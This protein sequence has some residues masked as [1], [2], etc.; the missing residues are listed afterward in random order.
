[1]KIREVNKWLKENDFD[2]RAKGGTTNCYTF[3]NDVITICKEP[4][5]DIFDFYLYCYHFGMKYCV[6][7][8]VMAI[9]HEVGHSETL[10]ELNDTLCSIDIFL[11]KL[12]DKL[13]D[14][15]LKKKLYYRLPTERA[16]TKWA[17][18]FVNNNVDETMRLEEIVW[19]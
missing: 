1:M 18:N 2:V 19:K 12:I 5:N 11:N 17:V 4:Y 13:P 6:D 3:E 15:K 9:L 14:G 16:A 10:L 8:H 7:P